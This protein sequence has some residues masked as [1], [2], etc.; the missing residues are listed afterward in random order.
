MPEF[1]LETESKSWIERWERF[2]GR[3]G[4]FP[5][6]FTFSPD[7]QEKYKDGIRVRARFFVPHNNR[8]TA[9]N[10]YYFAAYTS[11]EEALS[12]PIKRGWIIEM[13]D[14]DGS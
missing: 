4:V 8:A 10:T 12:Y 9:M 7:F 2:I 3:F 11:L 13:V 6:E 14:D 1:I 5:I